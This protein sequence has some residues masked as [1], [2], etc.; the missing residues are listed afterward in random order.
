MTY[1]RP[2]LAL[3]GTDVATPP[4]THG[5]PQTP[6]WP[7]VIGAHGGYMEVRSSSA[8]GSC[9]VGSYP[10]KHPGIDVAGDNG[11][12]VVAPVDGVI[13]ATADGTG[14]PFGGYGPWLVVI[15]GKD[16]YFQLL[17]HLDPNTS[18]QGPV[19]RMV[20]AG[21]QIGTVGPYYHT[22][23]E[24][25]TR[26]YPNFSA[27]ESNDT[28][29]IDPLVWLRSAKSPISTTAFWLLGGLALF[30]SILYRRL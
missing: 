27:G 24:V 9:G 26:A 2:Q 30:G 23:W 4:P 8:D 19:G 13:V 21:D 3:G 28:N 18:D 11:A 7:L 29:N 10:C 1:F 6:I 20:T 22:H 14:S 5:Q 25:R 17:G 15:Q 12:P 16:G